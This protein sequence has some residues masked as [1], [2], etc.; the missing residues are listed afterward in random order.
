MPRTKVFVSFD[1]SNDQTLKDFIVGKAKGSDS[2]FE[3]GGHSHKVFAPEWQWLE[4]AARAI[5]RAD[6]FIIMLGSR[7]RFSSAVHK[8]LGVAIEQEKRIL[9]IVGYQNGSADWA[10]PKAGQVYMWNWE[11]IKNLLQEPSTP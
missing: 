4:Q 5:S 6:V 1:C 9:Q 3:V 11:N 8:E 7:T 2:T 10:V